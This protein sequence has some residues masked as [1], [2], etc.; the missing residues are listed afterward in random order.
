MDAMAG[1]C[2]KKRSNFSLGMDEQTVEESKKP[3]K[4]LKLSLK[5]QGDKENCWG[6]LEEKEQDLLTKAYVLRNTLFNM[7]WALTH[8]EDWRRSHNVLYPNKPMPED[9]LVSTNT[10]NNSE[11]LVSFTAETRKKDGGQYPLKSV[12][13]LLYA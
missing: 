2:S 12:Y 13:L 10:M 3:K 8:F 4:K 6:F 5:E 11:W 9:L 7:K 1:S